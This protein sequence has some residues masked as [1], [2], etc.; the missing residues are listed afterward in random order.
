V[1]NGTT[2]KNGEDQVGVIKLHVTIDVE[3]P[4]RKLLEFLD[5]MEKGFKGYGAR[6]TTENVPPSPFTNTTPSDPA[7]VTDD[8]AGAKNHELL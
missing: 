5:H 6:V 7:T 2:E 8:S 3:L 1:V 4:V